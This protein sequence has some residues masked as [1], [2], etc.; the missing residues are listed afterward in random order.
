MFTIGIDPESCAWA[1]SRV[2]M[3]CVPPPEAQYMIIFWF[4]PL[5]G[6]VT[7]V[8]PVEL[9]PPQA[10]SSRA[11][12][13]AVANSPGSVTFRFPNRMQCLPYNLADV[14][15]QSPWMGARRRQVIPG[16]VRGRTLSR[17]PLLGI[18]EL[19]PPPFGYDHATRGHTGRPVTSTG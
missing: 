6:P 17:D 9:V 11:S 7:A 3:S 14:G 10:E 5:A 12:V 15:R 19:S 1:G 2:A 18:Y 8:G 16:V 4:A 13:P